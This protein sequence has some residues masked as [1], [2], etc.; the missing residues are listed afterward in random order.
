MK[1]FILFTFILAVLMMM[2]TTLIFGQTPNHQCGTQPYKSPFLKKYQA[3]P[4]AYLTRPGDLLM[5][6]L[7]IHNI[8]N[9][10]GLGHLSVDNVLEAVCNLNADFEAA[11]IQFYIEGEIIYY[12]NSSYYNHS[13]FVAGANMMFDNNIEN[14]INNYICSNPSGA[15]GYNLPYAGIA[16]SKSAISPGRHTW[17]PAF[18]FLPEP[19]QGTQKVR[20]RSAL[21]PEDRGFPNPVELFPAGTPPAEK[22]VFCLQ[23]L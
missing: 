8:G 22:F 17:A 21:R 7:T 19:F 4:S 2:S 15:A 23:G 14:T 3:N 16:L 6:P 12:S 1:R 20:F 11:D 18:E 13:T 10:N 9:D 5:V